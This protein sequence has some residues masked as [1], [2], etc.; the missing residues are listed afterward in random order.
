[1]V[2]GP[3]NLSAATRTNLLALKSTTDKIADVQNRLSTGLK[4][5][6]ALD[7]AISYFQAR[8]L[9]DRASDLPQ[10]PLCAPLAL[11]SS[12]FRARLARHAHAHRKQPAHATARPQASSGTRKGVS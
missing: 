6:S 10:A 1:M 11:H 12:G 8:A 5:S 3:M 2:D 4:V 9:N 7:N